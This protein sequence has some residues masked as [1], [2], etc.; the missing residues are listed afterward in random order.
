MLYNLPQTSLY[1]SLNNHNKKTYKIFNYTTKL[2]PLETY[3]KIVTP[4]YYHGKEFYILT[5]RSNDTYAVYR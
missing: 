5:S 3:L 4:S 1:T 2:Q